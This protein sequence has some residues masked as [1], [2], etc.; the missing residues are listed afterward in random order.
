M[1][2]LPEQGEG[3]HRIERRFL[4][5][6][7]SGRHPPATFTLVREKETAERQM[8]KSWP[9]DQARNTAVITTASIVDDGMPI[10]SVARDLDGGWQFLDG[11]DVQIDKARV[12]ALEEALSLD[13]SL[14]EIA[15]LPLGS[16]VTR[17]H[18][19][20]AWLRST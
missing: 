10:L 6:P 1:A 13:D 7:S 11:C 17:R 8:P 20:D 5:P 3:A 14:R 4:R 15:N 16:S 2:P 9:F 19:S 12:I 18:S